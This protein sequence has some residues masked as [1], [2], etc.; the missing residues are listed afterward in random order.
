MPS[1]ITSAIYEGKDES[2][3]SY[4]MQVGRQMMFAVML[5]DEPMSVPVTLPESDFTR[6]ERERVTK[7]RRRVI[8]LERMT[9]AEKAEAEAESFAAELSVWQSSRD[10]ED[11][12]RARYTAMREQ[13]EAWEPDPLIAYVKEHAL[14]FL[15]ESMRHDCPVRAPLPEGK[16]LR[17]LSKPEPMDPQAWWVREHAEAVKALE[18]AEEYLAK[19]EKIETERRA[20][21][22]A[23]LS[24]LPA[25]VPA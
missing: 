8:E 20:H 7:T 3:R 24:S 10:H 15:D 1:G 14:R 11:E 2:L 19:R 13:V 5:R 16:Y 21:I 17:W 9:D 23:F 4:L 6:Y 25:E 12:V 18:N 22:A